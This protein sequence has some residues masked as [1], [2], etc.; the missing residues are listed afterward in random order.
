MQ[1]RAQ[2]AAELAFGNLNSNQPAARIDERAAGE[3][4]FR[5][6]IG[7]DR[8]AKDA[9]NLGEVWIGAAEFLD[10]VRLRESQIDLILRQVGGAEWFERRIL[11][12]GHDLDEAQVIVAGDAEACARP[13]SCRHSR[14][15]GSRD[16]AR[17]PRAPP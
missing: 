2:N 15:R 10:L 13:P 7:P 4:I 1:P 9:A 12:I 14:S 5:V 11:A 8:A 17:S 3:P 16:S 6:Q